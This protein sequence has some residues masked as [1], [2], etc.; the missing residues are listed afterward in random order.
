M[1]ENGHRGLLIC[2]PE[3]LQV[4]RM[5]IIILMRA[6]CLWCQMAFLALLAERC[7]PLHRHCCLHA[8]CAADKQDA[9]RTAAILV[10]PP[11][12]TLSATWPACS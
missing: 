10:V 11:A 5:R 12:R 9:Q 4:D 8:H 6:L 3:L 1:L 7:L 2:G